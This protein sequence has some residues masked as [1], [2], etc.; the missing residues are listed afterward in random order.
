[1]IAS[2][3]RGRERGFQVPEVSLG[4]SWVQLGDLGSLSQPRERASYLARVAGVVEGVD[5]FG[6][7][8]HHSVVDVIKVGGPG[9]VAGITEQ[10]CGLGKGLCRVAGDRRP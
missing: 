8:V 10:L 6:A 2:Q 3:E 4:S 5:V 1:M 7:E 9:G